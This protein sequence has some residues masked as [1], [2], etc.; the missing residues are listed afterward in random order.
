MWHPSSD[1][2]AHHIKR[3]SHLKQEQAMTI[4]ASAIAAELSYRQTSVREG[5]ASQRRGR[6][7][8][9]ARRQRDLE[10]SRRAGAASTPTFPAPAPAVPSP[11]TPNHPRNPV[12]PEV[13]VGARHNDGARANSL[14]QPAGRA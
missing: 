12:K 10:R 6:R 13:V 1:A 2:Q 4:I 8:R 5:V 11:R 14:C 7:V 9:Q 3:T